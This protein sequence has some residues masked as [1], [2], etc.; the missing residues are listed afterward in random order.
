M[1]KKAL[2]GIIGILNLVFI[3]F[4]ILIFV[5]GSINAKGSINPLLILAY[6]IFI[7]I[8]L[9][10]DT[11]NVFINL[12]KLRKIDRRKRIIVFK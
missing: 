10:S 3:V 1:E 12:L 4:A 9:I 6:Q 11:I 7:L 5:I 2:F 8:C